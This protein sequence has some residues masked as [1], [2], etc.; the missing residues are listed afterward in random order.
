M[1]INFRDGYDRLLEFYRQFR[2]PK[3]EVE[4]LLLDCLFHLASVCNNDPKQQ[5]FR[6]KLV[7]T[8][9]EKASTFGLEHDTIA[10]HFTRTFDVFLCL[11]DWDNEHAG[12]WLK[13]CYFLMCVEEEKKPFLPPSDE[14]KEHMIW[15]K[16]HKFKLP[17][18]NL[19]N[20]YKTTKL[21]WRK[22]KF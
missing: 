9:E 18:N 16:S 4:G 19:E 2:G 13:S 8:F 21:P 15:V 10:E 11:E 12:R 5:E 22:L 3:S 7:T 17:F 6:R 14:E 20:T 1:L